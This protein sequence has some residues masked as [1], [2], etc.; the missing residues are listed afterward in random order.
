MSLDDVSNDCHDEGFSSLSALVLRPRLGRVSCRVFGVRHV[1]LSARRPSP[2][3]R[4]ATSSPP[5]GALGRPGRARC[6]PQLSRRARA[7]AEPT[8]T[9][10]IVWRHLLA[11]E[12]TVVSCAVVVTVV[13][14]DLTHY[15][16]MQILYMCTDVCWMFERAAR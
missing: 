6:Y 10:T 9:T 4:T 8:T 5:H 13:Y 15:Q 16:H 1:S 12:R 3:R 7:Q 14:R 2:A 11:R